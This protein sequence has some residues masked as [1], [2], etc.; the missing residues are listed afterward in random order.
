ME[1]VYN[2][3]HCQFYNRV[4][5]CLQL[6]KEMEDVYNSNR[7]QFYNRV[8]SCLQLHKEMEEV[9]I[10]IALLGRGFS[11]LD[12]RVGRRSGKE[13]FRFKVLFCSQLHF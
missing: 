10:S 4:F 1:D 9:V 2:G 3:N 7:S 13:V 5:S 6:H 8:F 12:G 11:C